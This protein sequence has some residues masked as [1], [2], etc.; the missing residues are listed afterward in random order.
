MGT[1]SGTE[2]ERWR[3]GEEEGNR[4]GGEGRGGGEK[5]DFQCTA[6]FIYAAS[7]ILKCFFWRKSQKK[8]FMSTRM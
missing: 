8:R 4:G 7:S 2:D 6:K 1:R 3:R 5:K